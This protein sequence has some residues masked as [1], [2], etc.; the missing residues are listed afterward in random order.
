MRCRY[1]EIQQNIRR[2]TQRINMKTHTQIFI[3]M[4][5]K[6]TQKLLLNCCK[7]TTSSVI[8]IIIH[9]IIHVS[10]LFCINLRSDLYDCSWTIFFI[11]KSLKI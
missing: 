8:I 2:P 3:D 7:S 10:N 4:A 6:V 11:L 1:F 9:I 5:L